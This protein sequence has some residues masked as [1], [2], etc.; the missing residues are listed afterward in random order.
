MD[1]REFITARLD[2]DEAVARAMNVIDRGRWHVLEWYNGEFEDG[3]TARADLRSRT[4]AITDGGALPRK[5]GDHIA[6]HDPARALAEVT[7]KR[8]RLERHNPG[9]GLF[10]GA[11]D[12]EWPCDDVLN[13]AAVYA[14]HPDYDPAWKIEP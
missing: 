13:D 12:D 4:G 8:R 1:I 6:R 11:C 5:V 10:C 7:A 3:Q 2:E 9:D 14:D